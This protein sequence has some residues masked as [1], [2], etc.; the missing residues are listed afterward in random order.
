VQ[1]DDGFGAG[2]RVEAVDVLGDDRL[3]VAAILE[4]RQGV[5]GGVGLDA[6]AVEG[7]VERE[8][9]R[10]ES[11]RVRLEAAVLEVRGVVGLPDAALA[12]EV[13]DAGGRA[14]TGPRERDGVVGV[15]EECR[16]RGDVVRGTVVLDDGALGWPVGSLL[17]HTLPLGRTDEKSP[18]RRVLRVDPPPDGG[19][20]RPR[21][22]ESNVP[23]A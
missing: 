13:G 11:G 9:V 7:L 2:G 6:V 1:A 16:E 22:L 12:P 19:Q 23:P 10:P 4:D 18:A 20:E 15:P 14:E 5:V 8:A 3:Q 17:V 21:E